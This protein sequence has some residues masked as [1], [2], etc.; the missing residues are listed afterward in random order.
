MPPKTP[1]AGPPAFQNAISPP[2]PAS[3]TGKSTTVFQIHYHDLP[4]NP[5]I[6]CALFVLRNQAFALCGT[7]AV[8]REEFRELV[9]ACP[10]VQF[11]LELP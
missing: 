2:P 11:T 5:S 4:G 10:N 7:F 1:R 8:Q 3:T 6:S 9:R